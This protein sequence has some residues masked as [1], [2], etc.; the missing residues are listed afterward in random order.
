MSMFMTE[1]TWFHLFLF[2]EKLLQK[3]NHHI[4]CYNYSAINFR[5][6]VPSSNVSGPEKK[7]PLGPLRAAGNLMTVQEVLSMSWIVDKF[8]IQSM[9]TW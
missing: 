1:F 3:L 9:I 6:F 2:E 7:A 5:Q 8:M 4:F